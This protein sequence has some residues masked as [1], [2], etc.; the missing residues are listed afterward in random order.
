MNRLELKTSLIEETEYLEK[1]KGLE[2]PFEMYQTQI[3]KIVEFIEEQ[4]RFLLQ[5][6]EDSLKTSHSI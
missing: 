2:K 3:V 5:A 6:K 4:F 1:L